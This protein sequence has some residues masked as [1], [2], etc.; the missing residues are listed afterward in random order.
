MNL[1]MGRIG[2]IAAASGFLVG[3]FLFLRCINKD[4]FSGWAGWDCY[5]ASAFLATIGLAGIFPAA[6]L[7]AVFSVAV[8]PFVVSVV[9][10]LV[11][12]SNDPS[13]CNLWPFGLAM[14]LVF[15]FPAPIVAGLI[16]HFIGPSRMHRTLYFA[17]LAAGLVVALLAPAIRF[18]QQKREWQS[19]AS[20]CIKGQGRPGDLYKDVCKYHDQYD[21]VL[22][23]LQGNA[24][25]V[26]VRAAGRRAVNDYMQG[27]KPAECN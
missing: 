14:A 15:G 21:S 27:L 11:S 25:A 23:C 13:C 26:S 22:S 8:G 24:G 3:G 5:Q 17:A 12:V 19:Y 9:E 20:S 4:A 6:R 2:T 10:L 7:Q 18:A 16:G 1:R